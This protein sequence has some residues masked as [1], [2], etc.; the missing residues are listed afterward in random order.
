MRFILSE[1]VNASINISDKHTI[2]VH[3]VT[4]AVLH[5]KEGKTDVLITSLLLLIHYL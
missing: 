3:D 5:P 4:N 1:C 2:S